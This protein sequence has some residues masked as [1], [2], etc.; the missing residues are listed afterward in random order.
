MRTRLFPV[1]C[2]HFLINKMT[3][4][5]NES[6]TSFWI[7]M[8][9]RIVVTSQWILWHQFFGILNTIQSAECTFTSIF[10]RA[11]WNVPPRLDL[12]TFAFP[13]SWLKETF[14]GQRSINTSLSS[15]ISLWK[16]LNIDKL[17]LQVK[18]EQ[19]TCPLRI[20]K[21]QRRSRAAFAHIRI[22]EVFMQT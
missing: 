17:I 6:Q 8:F 11:R 22:R 14:Y 3:N 16:S 9:H 2:H 4:S 7:C 1:S 12:T 20:M 13:R 19:T 18:Q 5:Q 21:E 15:S 10:N